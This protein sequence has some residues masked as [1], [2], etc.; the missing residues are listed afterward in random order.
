M[1]FSMSGSS[2]Y[3]YNRFDAF[4]AKLK[5]QKEEEVAASEEEEVIEEG[6]KP[7]YIDIDG[8]G[9]NDL[10]GNGDRDSY[11]AKFDKGGNLLF[12]QSLGGRGDDS[13]QGIAT[14][15]DGN[16]WTTGSFQG[17]I[18]ID[19]DGTNDL[20]SNSDRDSY[21][22]DSYV[23]KFDS[24]G[25]FLFAQKIGGSGDDSGYGVATDNDGNLW[26]TGEFSA[27]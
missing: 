19:Q 9:T 8:D 17:S 4:E 1:P 15:S 22:S 21:V 27:T 14:D 25:N 12:A 20:T 18:D 26:F 23:A 2:D 7:D 3:S 6:A 13:G 5:A 10:I 24:N 16:V 11:L